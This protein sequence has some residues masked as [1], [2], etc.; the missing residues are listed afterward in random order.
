MAEE[1]VVR[2]GRDYVTTFTQRETESGAPGPRAVQ[3]LHEL[4]PY[5]MILA[6]L[7]SCTALVVNS[8]A[9]HH[10]V[11]V[12][13]VVLTVEYRRSFREDCERCEELEKLG[14]QIR[15]VV[16]LEGALSPEQQEKLF[17]IAMQCPVHKMLTSGIKV[18]IEREGV[19]PARG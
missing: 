12:D 6:G 8:Y 13:A 5:G 18:V 11:P 17:K 16:A 2:Q 3:H 10:G 1:V 9:A 19:S 15:M 14:E 7:G 4:T